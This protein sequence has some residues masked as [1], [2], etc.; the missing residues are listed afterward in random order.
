MLT[1]INQRALATFV[2]DTLDCNELY[3][4]DAGAFDFQGARIYFERK[5]TMFVLH[6][7]SD[8]IKLPRC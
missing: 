7:G 3:E 1:Q 2:I 8:R 6:V 4:D 5:R